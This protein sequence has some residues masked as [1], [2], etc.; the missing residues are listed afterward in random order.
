MRNMR[1]TVTLDPDVELIV[2]EL[3]RTRGVTFKEAL[4]DAVRSERP[5]P[6]IGFS[7]IT[8]SLGL[9]SHDVDRAL[10]LAGDL[11]DAALLAKI[12]RDA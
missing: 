4:N 11:E 7:T 6:D 5:R 3:M 2:R 12:E 9:P 10:A 1:T 8:A